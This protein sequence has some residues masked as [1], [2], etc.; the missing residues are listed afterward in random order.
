MRFQFI[1]S[2][3]VLF[4]PFIVFYLKNT[5]R[6]LTPGYIYSNF[7]SWTSCCSGSKRYD[8]CRAENGL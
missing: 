2:I 5:K 1:Q 8:T 3:D 6:L 4:V 7:G